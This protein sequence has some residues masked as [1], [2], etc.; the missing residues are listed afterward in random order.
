LDAAAIDGFTAF[1]DALLHRPALGNVVVLWRTDST[2]SA[3]RRIADEFAADEAEAPPVW[4][5][6]YQQARG[7]GRQGRSWVS[8]PAR[9]VYATL[10]MSALEPAAL[11]RL[12]LVAAIALSE[13]IEAITGRWCRVKWPNDLMIGHRKIG[14]ILI[15]SMVRA[16]QAAAAIC[17][18][19]VN[20]SHT[21][22]ELPIDAATSITLEMA[23]GAVPPLGDTAARLAGALARAFDASAKGVQVGEL[24]ARYRARSAHGEGDVLR[25][26]VGNDVVEGRFRGFDERG[27]LRLDTPQGPRLLSAGEVIER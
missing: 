12:P 21:A 6:A 24:A 20:W 27:F 2:N 25:C 10:L 23:D 7:R 3:A 19:G 17:G 14:G 22:A 4:V 5:F 15:E 26:S 9:G 1:A 18:F 8:L 11:E 16:E 13:E